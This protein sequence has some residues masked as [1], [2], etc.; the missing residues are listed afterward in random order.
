MLTNNKR[1]RLSYYEYLISKDNFRLV[2]GV[3]ILLEY[4]LANRLWDKY[5]DHRTVRISYKTKVNCLI[6]KNIKLEDIIE[7]SYKDDEDFKDDDLSEFDLCGTTIDPV[8]F[9]KF[10]RNNGLDVPAELLEFAGLIVMDKLTYDYVDKISCQAVART[11]WDM[12]PDMTT[13]D[14]INHKA[15]Q[16][17]AGGK[18]KAYSTLRKWISAEDKRTSGTKPGPNKKAE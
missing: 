6:S 1:D 9:I 5:E 2:D 7:A 8:V 14:I 15:I 10:A 16:L 4:H 11:L 18:T 17:H 13:E 12:Y 3:A